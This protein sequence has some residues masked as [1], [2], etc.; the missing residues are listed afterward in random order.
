MTTLHESA[1]EVVAVRR[2]NMMAESRFPSSRPSGWSQH[3]ADRGRRRQQRR[4]HAAR[5]LWRYLSQV[6]SALGAEG[7]A[8]SDAR[9]SPGPDLEA[10]L[11][12][13]P[14]ESHGGRHSQ[15][16]RGGSSGEQP[17]GTKPHGGSVGGLLDRPVGSSFELSWAEDT[18]WRI[19]HHLLGGPTEAAPWRYLHLELVP[20]PSAVARFTAAVLTDFDDVGMPYPAQFRYRS[21]PLRP[22]IDALARH[23]TPP[24]SATHA[25]TS[26]G[27]GEIT[28]PVRE[29]RADPVIES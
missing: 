27:I 6:A 24:D 21:Q 2:M 15:P 29:E 5:L 1:E 28:A 7:F 4:E 22:V 17:T 14:N 20:A 9:I 23:A 13:H 10:Q 19:E 12:V 16:V 8:I 26:E 3:R 18:G 25:A 11:R